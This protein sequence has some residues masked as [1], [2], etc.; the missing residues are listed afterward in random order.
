M[1]LLVLKHVGIQNGEHSAYSYCSVGYPD[2][3]F[4]LVSSVLLL[5]LRKMLMNQR[6][7]GCPP[8]F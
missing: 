5:V 4:A 7:A 8:S 3:S 2:V 1:Q 6:K